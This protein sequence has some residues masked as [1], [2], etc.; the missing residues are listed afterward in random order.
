MISKIKIILINKRSLLEKALRKYILLFCVFLSSF[1][2]A[3]DFHLSQ[4]DAPP[5]F[6]NP[7]MTGMFDGYYRVHAHYRTQWSSIIKNPFT[8]AG[9]SFDMPV[10]KFG[11]GL[12]IFNY[13]AGTGNYNVFSALLSVGYD[14][15]FDKKNN[16]HLALGIQT[17]IVQKSVNLDKLTFGNQY[18][19]ANGGGFDT[20]IPNGEMFSNPNFL[21]HDI[22]A[23]F[24]YYFAKDNSRLNPFIG[25]SAF[26][27]TQPKESFLGTNN[28]LPIRYYFHGGVKININEKIQ[29][30][31]KCIYM[32]QINDQEFTATLLLHYFLRDSDTYLIFGP[33]YRNKDAAIIEGG[34]KK[35]RYI[36][37]ISYDINTSSLKKVSDS[38]GGFEISLTYIARKSKPNPLANCPR[39]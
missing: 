18:T 9:L 15:V 19:N 6:L 23:G 2:Y 7:A 12:Q 26:H 39:L 35:G 20:G 21:I 11:I 33:T 3:Q 25:I 24:L 29:L 32:R 5:L 8:T 28:K 17:G 16:H 4:Y 38:R 22:N 10:K 36:C 30:L 27:L 1:T 14:V 31:P 37:R 13:R 34:I